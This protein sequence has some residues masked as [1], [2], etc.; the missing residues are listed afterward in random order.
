[1]AT[2][3]AVPT[4]IGVAPLEVYAQISTLAHELQERHAI[5][6]RDHVKPALDEAG[7][8]IEMWSDLSEEDRREVGKT[9]RAQIFPVLTPLAV[10]PA[11]P[12]PY[13]S[14]LSLSLSVQ[15]RDPRTDR[16][17]FARVKVPTILPRFVQLP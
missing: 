12:F 14:G 15:V 4:N 7:I 3:L 6:F 17:E 16:E 2:G 8:H 13:I 11:H 9:Y 1:I 5:A 10:D